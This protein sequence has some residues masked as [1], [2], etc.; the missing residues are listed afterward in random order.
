MTSP[1]TL[2]YAALALGTALAA[3][4]GLLPYFMEA[5]HVLL[6]PAL[7]VAL[8]TFVALLE[9]PTRRRTRAL[10]ERETALQ[11]ATWEYSVA[12]WPEAVRSAPSPGWGVNLGTTV[13]TTLCVTLVA[14]VSTNDLRGLWLGAAWAVVWSSAMQ[15]WFSHRDAALANHPARTLCMTRSILM[16]GD[17]LFILNPE[18][19][20]PELGAGTHLHHCVASP[21]AAGDTNPHFAGTL[22]WTCLAWSRNSRRR[23]EYRF[24]IPSERA[25]DVD[26]VVAAYTAIGAPNRADPTLQLPN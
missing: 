14:C 10:L 26:R 23:V 25:H 21:R 13:L 5:P 6:V 20:L 9:V 17:Q 8:C 7:A 15:A 19:A 24:P 4:W 12:A 1:R 16:L 11:V 18:P 22:T 3:A 2:A